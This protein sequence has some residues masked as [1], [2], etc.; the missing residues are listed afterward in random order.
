MKAKCDW[1]GKWTVKRIHCVSSRGAPKHSTESAT[2]F[3]LW[4]VQNPSV[5]RSQCQISDINM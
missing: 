2:P 1:K 3:L 5:L 4:S